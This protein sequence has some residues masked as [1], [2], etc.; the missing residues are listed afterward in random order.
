MVQGELFRDESSTSSLGSLDRDRKSFL[1]RH[2][3]TLTYDKLLVV[4]IAWVIVF[5]LTYS[6]GVEHGKR[7]VERSLESLLPAHT[8]TVSLN[9]GSKTSSETSTLNGETVI[10]VNQE[11][12]VDAKHIPA[13]QTVSDPRSPSSFPVADLAKEGS[14]TVQL[15]TY[16]NEKQAI[17]EIDHLKTK[18]HEGFVIPSGHY[19][20][21]CAN[22]FDDKVKAGNFL[23][24]FSELSRYPDAYVRPVVR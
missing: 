10:L 19:Y 7:A 21:V 22:Y 14:Y 6:F 11:P 17:R 20:Q 12:A 13:G 8:D 23:K 24:Q 5:A 15:V 18:G 9:V 2:Q 4:L 3:L 1:S 16:A